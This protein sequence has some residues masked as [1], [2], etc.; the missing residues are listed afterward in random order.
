MTTENEQEV[1]DILRKDLVLQ[2]ETPEDLDWDYFLETALKARF[3]A[4][5]ANVNMVEHERSIEEIISDAK[6]FSGVR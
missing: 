6:S 3:I 2:L 4:D 1:L 5:N